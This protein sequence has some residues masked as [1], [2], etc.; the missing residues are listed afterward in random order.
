MVS[1]IYKPTDSHFPFSDGEDIDY[2]A[3]H[4]AAKRR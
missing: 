1:R 4:R 3:R 2:I